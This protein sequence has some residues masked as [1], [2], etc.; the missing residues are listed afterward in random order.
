MKQVQMRAAV[1][2][3]LLG[4]LLNGC[5]IVAK[6]RARDDMEISKARYKACL[7]QNPQTLANCES[8]RL[9]YEADLRA[10]KATSAGI[11][12]GPTVTIEEE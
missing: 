3:V 9:A 11:R 5:G 4:A 7:E 2:L 8:A 12:S 1:I 6:V 10:Y